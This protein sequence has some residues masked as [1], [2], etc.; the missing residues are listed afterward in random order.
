MQ[1][2]L[3]SMSAGQAL[4][5]TRTNIRRA[6]PKFDDHDVAGFQVDGNSLVVVRIDGSEQIIPTA[7]VKEAFASYMTRLPH[8]F[9]YMGANYTTPR[10][11]K[12]NGYIVM[13]GHSYAMQGGNLS[14]GAISQRHFVKEHAENVDQQTLEHVLLEH[15]IGYLCAPDGLTIPPDDQKMYLMGEGPAHQE[16][17]TEPYCSCGSFRRQYAARAELAAEIPGY[18]PCCKH[19]TWLRKLREY[20]VKRTALVAEQPTA[21]PQKCAAYFYAPP[22]G[23]SEEGTVQI[24]FTDQGKLAPISQWKLYKPQKKAKLNQHDVWGLLDNMIEKGYVPFY[25]K[26]IEAVTRYFKQQIQ[27]S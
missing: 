11:W 23:V 18:K 13:K 8:H 3:Q 4:I 6:F 26:N 20:Q 5:Y 16:Q 24:L 2:K 10:Y 7:P 21:F 1:T 17:D 12:N 19:M 14:P 15:N 9:E 27:S 22:S 25:Y